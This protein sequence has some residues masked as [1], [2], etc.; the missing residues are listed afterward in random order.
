MKYILVTGGVISGIGKGVIASSLGTILKSSGVRVTSIK[1]DP[2]INIDA[3][4]FSPY[5]HGEVF[6]L[7]DGGEVD[8]D[9]G[10]YERFLDVTL[11]RDNNIT[12]GK[13]YQHVINKERRGDYLGKTVQVVPHITDAI[14]EWVERVAKVPVDG[15]NSPPDLCIIELGGTI[16][17]IEGMPFVEAFRQ[18]QFRVKREN[19]CLVHVSL[20]PQPKA[21]GEQKTK[22]TQSSIRELRGLGL[23]PDLIVC[24]CT[25]PIDDAVREKVSLFC[26]VEPQQVLSI[27]DLSSIYRVPL[28]ME[29]QGVSRYMINRLQLHP[30]I[31]NRPKRFMADWKELADR[32]DRLLREVTIALVG[33]YTKLEDAYASVIKALQH[34]ALAVSHRLNLR[35]IAASDLEMETLSQDPVRYHE[36]WHQLVSANGVLVPGG[37]GQRGIEG[38]ILAVNWARTKKVPFLGI[39]LGLQCAAIEFARNV[40][41]MKDANS[42]EFHATTKYPV[43]IEMPE[44]NTGVM[45]GTMRLGLRKTIFN[46]D[47]CIMKKLYGN[48]PF[49]E[50]RHR[51]RYEINPTFVDKYEAKGMKFVGRSEDG[52]RMEILELEGHPFFVGVQYHPEYISRPMKPSAPY[53]GF[54]L[55][56]CGK[57]QGFAN[58]GFR[59]SPNMN[60]SESSDYDD[61]ELIKI[62]ESVSKDAEVLVN[63]PLFSASSTSTSD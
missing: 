50:E 60:Y 37:F 2:Y 59:K 62:N 44:H 7:N 3:G 31:A 16:G 32:Y 58:R 43:V 19:F 34:S 22:P 6:V 17:D 20:V 61:E 10:N 33:K 13:I 47:K 25:N 23:S 42:T 14:Q 54:L 5:E 41:D 1:I 63:G 12:T 46:S 15:D 53:F 52:E 21:T 38:K 28:L 30:H 24:R 9:L 36:A 29:E 51:H 49:V 27:H 26:H 56:S 55:A 4:T 8:L 39:C 40:L 45:G 35:Y 48:V 18:F 57:L 11:H